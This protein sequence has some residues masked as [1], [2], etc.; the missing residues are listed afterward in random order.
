M[1]SQRRA[2]GKTEPVLLAAQFSV[3][4][5]F[6]HFIMQRISDRVTTKTGN[7]VLCPIK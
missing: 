4:S 3:V 2:G 5:P 7:V 6:R 1:R